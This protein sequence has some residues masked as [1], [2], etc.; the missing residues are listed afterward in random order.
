MKKHA[1][2]IITLAALALTAC[3]P[4]TTR[5]THHN[6][7]QLN[8]FY[9]LEQGTTHE[10][11][12]PDD[13]QQTITTRITNREG[14]KLTIEQRNENNALILTSALITNRDGVHAI[15]VTTPDRHLAFNP[16]ITILPAQNQLRAGKTWENTH[17]VTETTQPGAAEPQTTTWT[18]TLTGSIPN[19][20]IIRTGRTTHDAY[21]ITINTNWSTANN[22]VGRTQIST[23]WFAP[24]TGFITTPDGHT[25]TNATA[26]D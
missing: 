20:Q 12:H 19:R 18:V 25:L 13:P 14:N 26:N 17:T 11:T 10:Y 5:I 24:H 8:E 16:P 23:F 4:T 1:L 9:P 6:Q 7:M 21:E 3:S 22:Q 15:E 2:A